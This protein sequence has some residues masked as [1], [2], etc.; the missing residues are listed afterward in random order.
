MTRPWTRVLVCG[1]RDYADRERVRMAMRRLYERGTLVVIHG[2]APGADTMAAEEW[3]AII[4]EDHAR[5]RAASGG[6]RN[7]DLAAEGWPADWKRLGRA[8]GPIRNAHMITRKPDVVIA[9]P[10]GRGTADMIARATAAGIPVVR[11]GDTT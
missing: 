9:F 11:I 6:K 7:S 2:A 4:R 3:R 10:G 8:A 5:V 1:G